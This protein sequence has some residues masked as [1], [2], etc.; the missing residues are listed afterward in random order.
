MTEEEKAEETGVEN[1]G[2]VPPENISQILV[3]KA[4]DS[5]FLMEVR[6]RVVQAMAGQRPVVRVFERMTYTWSVLSLN[7]VGATTNILYS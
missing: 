4:S 2:L 5:H 6:M 1:G 3:M 7:E